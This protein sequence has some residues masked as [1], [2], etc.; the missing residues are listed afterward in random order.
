M[1]ISCQIENWEYNEFYWNIYDYDEKLNEILDILNNNNQNYRI[2]R[3][4]NKSSESSMSRA[5]YDA[6]RASLSF[7]STHFNE[8][9]SWLAYMTRR[10]VVAYIL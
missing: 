4:G 3:V 1:I 6:S 8:A 5:K 7:D 9:R 2:N 10:N